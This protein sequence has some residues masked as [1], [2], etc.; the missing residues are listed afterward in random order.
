[1]PSAVYPGP[2]SGLSDRS[3]VVV[4]AGFSVRSEEGCHLRERLR[5]LGYLLRPAPASP[6]LDILRR[7]L[8]LDQ[9]SLTIIFQVLYLEGEEG[10]LRYGFHPLLRLPLQY[11][12]FLEPLGVAPY[13]PASCE[14]T[15]L[16]HMFHGECLVVSMK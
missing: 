6:G 1:M 5:D 3:L 15:A 10:E 2:Y 14:A 8:S 7:R 12:L 4:V 16:F 11:V 13:F 9:G